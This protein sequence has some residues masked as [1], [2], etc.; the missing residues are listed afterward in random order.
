MRATDDAPS[1][2]L[3]TQCG[4]GMSEREPSLQG[5]R[6]E[7]QIKHMYINMIVAGKLHLTLKGLQNM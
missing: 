3:S 6:D 7:E 5:E 1:V 4:L 2:L